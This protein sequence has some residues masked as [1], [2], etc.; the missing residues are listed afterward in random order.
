MRAA[1]ACFLGS[2]LASATICGRADMATALNAYKQGDHAAAFREFERLAKRGDPAAQYN[3]GYML[4]TGEGI[5]KDVMSGFG[6][7]VAAE[8]NGASEATP[9]LEQLRKVAKP[10]QLARAAAFAAPYT[11]E[12]L[13]TAYSNVTMP[14][15]A[16]EQTPRARERMR[17]VFPDEAL[18]SGTIGVV[19]LLI[20]IDSIGRVRDAWGMGSVP[21][22]KFDAF[23][24]DGVMKRAFEPATLSGAPTPAVGRLRV[25][26]SVAGT[27]G[28]KERPKLVRMVKER[29]AEADSDNTDSQYFVYRLGQMFSDLNDTI[30][31]SCAWGK[32]AASGGHAGAMLHLGWSGMAA[33]ECDVSPQQSRAYLEKAAIA[34]VATARLIIALQV[35]NRG[36]EE[37]QLQ[38]LRW[39][40]PAA[41][42]GNTT[43]LKL[44]AHLEASSTFDSVRDSANAAK[45]TAALL[46]IPA[47]DNDPDLWQIS[48]AAAAGQGRWQDAVSDQERAIALAK[49]VG[50]P[51]ADFEARLAALEAK[52]ELREDLLDLKLVFAPTLQGVSEGVDTCDETARTGSRLARCE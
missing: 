24:R 13:S 43:A 29:L 25:R 23:A 9:V 30:G 45:T 49:R 47:R 33:G 18:Y 12:G 15:L 50:W 16:T 4:V 17:M 41:R 39:L 27:G 38:A 6:W 40:A 7:L 1:W 14:V 21:S 22:Q 8:A 35:L 44:Q 32:K 42:G 36:G 48:A 20:V 34:G 28:A 19:D 37:S 26:Y 3:T 51:T 46:A 5:P 2:V 10:A 31:D 11:Q 52:R